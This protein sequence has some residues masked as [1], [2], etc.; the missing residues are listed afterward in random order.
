VWAVVVCTEPFE[1]LARLNAR[2]RGA[3]DLDLVVLPHP[4]GVRPLDEVRQ[5]GRQVAEHVAAL[6]E[7]R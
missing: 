6:A 7:P 3:E 5:L 2:A 4:L 1:A